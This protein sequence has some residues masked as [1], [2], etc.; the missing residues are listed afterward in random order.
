[1]IQ[2]NF[3]LTFLWFRVLKCEIYL[4]LN[5]GHVYKTPIKR[6]YFYLSISFFSY[7]AINSCTKLLIST[8]YLHNFYLYVSVTVRKILSLYFYKYFTER[9]KVFKYSNSFVLSHKQKNNVKITSS[10]LCMHFSKYG[11]RI[12][13]IV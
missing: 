10:Y 12:K 5:P 3:V 8:T 1:M 4:L 13:I 7:L 2:K 6:L 11:A 9:E